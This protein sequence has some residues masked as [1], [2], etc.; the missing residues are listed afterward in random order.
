MQFFSRRKLKSVW[1]KVNKEKVKRLIEEGLMTHAGHAIIETAKQNGSWYILDDAE[2]LVVPPDLEDAFRK[3]P[4]A[5]TYFQSLS[6]SDKRN[7]LQWLVLA[8][9]SETR[10]KRITELVELASQNQK[11]KQFR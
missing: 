1:S 5:G 8:K 11:P 10:I 9:K 4:A 3:R 7:M 6:R 2:A